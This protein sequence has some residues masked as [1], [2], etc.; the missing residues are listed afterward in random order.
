MKEEAMNRKHAVLIALVLAFAAVAAFAAAMHTV[1]LGAA[2]AAPKVATTQIANRN[3]QLARA[4]AALRR[5]ARQR[6]PKLPSV[7]RVPPARAVASV[8]TAPAIPA[9]A[10]MSTAPRQA[11]IYVRPAPIVHVIH[12]SGGEHEAEHGDDHGDG[13]GGGGADD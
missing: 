12:R 5:S 9:A 4:E 13:H 3:A 1:R 8:S 2:S 7:P 6:P 11:V 10:R